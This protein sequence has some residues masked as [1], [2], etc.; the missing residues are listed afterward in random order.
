MAALRIVLEAAT[1][2]VR[3]AA[4]TTCVVAL[5]AD[6][7]ELAVQVDDDG[8]GMPAEAVPGVGSSSMR[9]RAEEVGGTLAVGPRPGGGT[10][11]RAV[12][13]LA[14]AGRAAG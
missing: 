10:R 14:E 7:G 1:N 8:S 5:S 9:E 13:P 12:L 2:V 6:G 3:H 4:A 11:V